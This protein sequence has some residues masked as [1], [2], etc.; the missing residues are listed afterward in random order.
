M[1]DRGYYGNP[2]PLPP[3]RSGGGWIKVAAVAG[4][5]AAIWFWVIPAIGSKPK[6]APP[7]HVPP[8]LPP[9]SPPHP[10]DEVAHS[11]G[12]SSGPAYEDA[13][14]ATARELESAGARVD[15]GPHLAHLG[16]RVS[17]RGDER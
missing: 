4:L 12:F 11:R 17:A 2:A 1:S 16:S 10:L 3:R 14:V 6:L 8:P 7:P 15:L 13:L 5:G 9:A